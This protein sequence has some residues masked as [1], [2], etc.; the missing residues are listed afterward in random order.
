MLGRPNCPLPV[1]M[2]SL[3]GAWLKRLVAQVF[4]RAMSST[5][6]AVCGSKSLTLAPD[7][8]Y[9]RKVRLDPSKVDLFLKDESMKAKRLPSRKES[10]MG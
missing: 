2:K 3:A 9:W 7:C 1:F 5:M 4:T 10:G 8:P 6:P